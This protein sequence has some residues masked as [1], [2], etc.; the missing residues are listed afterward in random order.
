[1]CH[2]HEGQI[3]F[4]SKVLLFSP[5]FDAF[6]KPSC[7]IFVKIKTN[8]LPKS[9]ETLIYKYFL[10]CAEL[11]SS[12]K[13]QGAISVDEATLNTIS[14]DRIAQNEISSVQMLLSVFAADPN[15][16]D[17]FEKIP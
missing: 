9:F 12:C 16:F 13:R 15:I 14:S 6:A 4:Q 7:E 17:E 3:L 2:L 10:S 11:C 5:L 1:M 8:L